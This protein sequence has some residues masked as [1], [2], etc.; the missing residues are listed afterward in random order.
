LKAP[1]VSL[2]D[3]SM[4]ELY[5]ARVFSSCWRGSPV[6]LTLLSMVFTNF[7]VCSGPAWLGAGGAGSAARPARG[8]IGCS[9]I[10]DPGGS[11]AGGEVTESAT[12]RDGPGPTETSRNW[13]LRRP[14]AGRQGPGG[15]CAAL[16]G[17]A[18]A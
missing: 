15:P 12:G 8:G 4:I 1:F 17:A 16:L 6:L 5:P 3:W 7:C 2:A 13:R 14:D 18:I 11:C 9:I 10:G